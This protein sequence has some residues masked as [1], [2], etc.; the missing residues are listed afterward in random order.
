MG[1]LHILLKYDHNCQAYHS[2]FSRNCHLH[3]T[4]HLYSHMHKHGLSCLPP[5]KVLWIN[6]GRN[7]Y[8]PQA[9]DN[10]LHI[11]F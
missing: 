11:L 2:V 9:M 7:D 10:L 8:H 4:N 5:T 3:Q 6:R 1:M